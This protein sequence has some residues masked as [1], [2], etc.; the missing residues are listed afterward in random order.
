MLT[1]CEN[2][3]LE[4]Y[5]CTP[6]NRDKTIQAIRDALPL[7]EDNEIATTMTTIIR[8]INAMS[9]TTFEKLSVG[10]KTDYYSPED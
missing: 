3:I 7:V 6:P 5:M 9:Q 10:T 1:C 2:I 4:M 8:K